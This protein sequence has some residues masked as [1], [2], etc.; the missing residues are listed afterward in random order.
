MHDMD[1]KPVSRANYF[2]ESF[3]LSF[4]FSYSGQI[5][6]L[7]WPVLELAYGFWHDFRFL[8]V[9]KEEL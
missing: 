3:R 8:A 4:M 1:F 2:Q 7:F 6:S 9:I 5:T